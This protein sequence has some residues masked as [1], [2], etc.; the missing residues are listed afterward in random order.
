ML[1][2]G[3]MLR[4]P[5]MADNVTF[6][7]REL[8]PDRRIVVWAHNSHVRHD[9]PATMYAPG[10]RMGTFVAARHRPELYTVGLYMYRG[11]SASNSR[12]TQA[13]TPHG[14]GSL[15]SILYRTRRKYA[16]V[17]LLGPSRTGGSEWIFQPVVAKEWGQ[18]PYR[19]VPRDQYDGILF[20]DSTSVP[21]YLSP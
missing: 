8:Y 3:G 6:L 13:V 4:D 18:F 5:G 15:E 1:P 20:V 17:D 14:S 9:G 21:R 10:N 11:T 2:G 16:F 7:L 19:M 12:Q